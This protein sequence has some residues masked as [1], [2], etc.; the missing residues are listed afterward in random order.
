MATI[1]C[2]SRI[3][4]ASAG[5][6]LCK[7]VSLQKTCVYLVSFIAIPTLAFRILN[8]QFDTIRQNHF[9]KQ[10]KLIMVTKGLILD[11]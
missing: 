3:A 7:A 10:L 6:A 1:N 4:P 11:A 9:T 8:S 5:N 2:L